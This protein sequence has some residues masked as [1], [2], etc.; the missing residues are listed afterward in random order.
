MTQDTG[1]SPPELMLIYLTY[2][3]GYIK[4]HNVTPGYIHRVTND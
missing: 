1:K 4:L 3:I 2:Y